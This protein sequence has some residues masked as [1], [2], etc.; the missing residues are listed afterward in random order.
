MPS[1]FRLFGPMKVEYTGNI[2]L[3]MTPSSQL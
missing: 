2:F 3:T 1:D